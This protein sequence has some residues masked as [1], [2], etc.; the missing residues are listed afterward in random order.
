MERELKVALK[1]RVKQQVMDAV[2]DKN[3]IEVPGAFVDQEV[4][5]MRGQM[6]QQFGGNFDPSS[7]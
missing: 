7:T 2:L 1:N 5:A 6:L 3:P 4:N